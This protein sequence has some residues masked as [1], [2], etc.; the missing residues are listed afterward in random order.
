MEGT[1]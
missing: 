1:P